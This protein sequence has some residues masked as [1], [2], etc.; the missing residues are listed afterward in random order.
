MSDHSK[1]SWTDATWNCVR[2]CTKVSAG[3]ANCFAERFAE[4][5]R[6]IPGHPYEQGFDVRLVP[7][8]LTLPLRWRKPRRIFVNSMSD[9]FHEAVPFDFVDEVFGVMAACE[10][11][12][13]DGGP[14]HVFQ[15]LTKRPERMREYLST[16]RTRTWAY[17]AVRHGGGENPDPLFDQIDAGPRCPPNVWLGVSVENQAA[18]DERIPHLLATPAAVRFISAEPLLGPVNLRG[19]LLS[20]AVPGYC[21]A[22]GGHHGFTRCPNTGGIARTCEKTGCS[23]FRRVVGTGLDWV[24]VGAESGPKAR[25]VNLSWISSLVRQCRDAGTACFVKQ[26]GR[27]FWER[28]EILGGEGHAGKDLVSVMQKPQ[29]PAQAEGWT[30]VHT[31]DE[32]YLARY[33]ELH[34]RSGSDPSEWPPDLRVQ[35]MPEVR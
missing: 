35:Q 2:G 20:H 29:H 10:C 28:T 34:D 32:E 19:H 12:T 16:D 4:R 9:L 26:L 31:A 23:T 21:A 30:R 7:E 3:C 8:A 25:P 33:T 1:I 11:T 14:G 5:W 27:R 17:A 22:C 13:R 15:V 6:G 24:I 18:A